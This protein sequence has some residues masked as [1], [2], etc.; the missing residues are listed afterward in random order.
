M[1]ARCVQ[2]IGY[3]YILYIE[4]G[5]QTF[6]VFFSVKS[7]LQI[8]CA[9][10]LV[11]SVEKM[12]ETLEITL[13][14]FL[15]KNVRVNQ[16]QQDAIQGVIKVRSV[17]KW[18]VHARNF[19]HNG[20]SGR[21]DGTAVAPIREDIRRAQLWTYFTNGAQFSIMY[22]L[23][24]DLLMNY[25]LESDLHNCT[26]RLSARVQ[27]F[28]QRTQLDMQWCFFKTFLLLLH[29]I[30]TRWIHTIYYRISPKKEKEVSFLFLFFTT[31]K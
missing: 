25:R 15:F 26:S 2:Y 14:S 13:F 30:A 9:V 20:H 16:K 19:P 5:I 7:R 24:I 11:C 27:N 29:D 12:K 8:Q 18:L 10:V 6:L 4:L 28:L 22:A 31:L 3:V 17:P 23:R 21:L 1:K